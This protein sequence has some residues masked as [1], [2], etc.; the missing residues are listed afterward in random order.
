MFS[1]Q[2]WLTK[3]KNVQLSIQSHQSRNQEF[4]HFF[5]QAVFLVMMWEKKRRD[6][7]VLYKVV[8]A[9]DGGGVCKN[10]KKQKANAIRQVW[11]TFLPVLLKKG[12]TAGHP[13]CGGHCLFCYTNQSHIVCVKLV[14]NRKMQGYLENI[15][16]SFNI[17]WIQYIYLPIVN[18]IMTAPISGNNMND[19]KI[20]PLKVSL[21]S[22]L[23]CTLLLD[24][25]SIDL[26]G[27]QEKEGHFH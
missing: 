21:G 24:E 19:L 10:S 12:T 3:G 14:P 23:G 15:L 8:A 6:S 22:T 9:V 18:K 7:D 11:Q 13:S 2:W 20:H 26:S 25:W 16:K 27:A 4:C 1:F 17:A 5:S